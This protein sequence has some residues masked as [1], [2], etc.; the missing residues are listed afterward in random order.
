MMKSKLLVQFELRKEENQFLAY[1]KS[2]KLLRKE[3]LRIFFSS[4]RLFFFY[5][6]KISNFLFHFV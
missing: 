6:S 2:S 1:I 4:L 5:V 3:G